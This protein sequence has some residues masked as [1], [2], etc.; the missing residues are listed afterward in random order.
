MTQVFMNNSL[1]LMANQPIINPDY[2]I[3][4]TKNFSDSW[5][6]CMLITLIFFFSLFY[7]I[8]FGYI[9]D[10]CQ[11]NL[12][13]ESKP[14]DQNT[15]GQGENSQPSEG[16]NSNE[17]STNNE[18]GQSGTGPNNEQQNNP[19]QNDNSTENQGMFNQPPV[20][21]PTAGEEVGLTPSEDYFL[22]MHVNKGFKR[23]K[24][25]RRK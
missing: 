17:P 18:G 13:D 24:Q 25:N 19:D 2:L 7:F 16:P 1:S 14:K 21:G 3:I 6:S 10:Q 4:F 8:N 5:K 20:E 9:K 12:T 15:Q 22:A 23:N 11:L